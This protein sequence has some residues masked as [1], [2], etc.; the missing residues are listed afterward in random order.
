VIFG[1]SG[2]SSSSI[3]ALHSDIGGLGVRPLKLRFRF[4]GQNRQNEAKKVNFR[5]I[6]GQNDRK[7]LEKYPPFPHW[8]ENPPKSARLAPYIRI[9]TPLPKENEKMEG[10]LIQYQVGRGF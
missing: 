8:G 1:V 4:R 6:F 10:E 2:S 7:L 5:V 3:S 9:P